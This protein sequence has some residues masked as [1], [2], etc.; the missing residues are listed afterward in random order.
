M[1]QRREPVLHGQRGAPTPLEKAHI[2]TETWGSFRIN[3]QNL[4]KTNTFLIR[5]GTW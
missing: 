2:A 5:E 4:K 1:S 3:T